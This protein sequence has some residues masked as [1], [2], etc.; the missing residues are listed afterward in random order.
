MCYHSLSQSIK[1]EEDSITDFKTYEPPFSFMST[2]IDHGEQRYNLSFYKNRGIMDDAEFSTIMKKK[3]ITT[4][5]NYIDSGVSVKGVINQLNPKHF[6]L[7]NYY[8]G[9]GNHSYIER[10]S[11]MIKMIFFIIMLSIV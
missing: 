7:E 4:F 2:W 11:M 8:K 10:M 9:I 1:P 5:W 6:T 3:G